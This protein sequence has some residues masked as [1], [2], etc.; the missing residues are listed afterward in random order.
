VL[1]NQGRLTESELA[2]QLGISRKTLWERR[3]RMGLP[4]DKAS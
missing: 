3:T 1:Q 4:R 2:R